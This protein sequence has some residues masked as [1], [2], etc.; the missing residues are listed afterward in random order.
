MKYL[1]FLFLS[2]ISLAQE[3]IHVAVLDTGLDLNKYSSYICPTGSKDFTGY[4]I[5]DHYGHGTFITDL[6]IRTAQSAGKYCLVILKEYDLTSNDKIAIPA[7][8]AALREAIHLNVNIIN[9]SGIGTTP[10]SEEKELI[11]SH[12][13]IKFIVAAGNEGADMDA[14]QNCTYPA[15]YGLSNVY[16]IGNGSKGFR[17]P[18]SNYGKVV[19]HWEDGEY[20]YGPWLDKYIYASGTSMST[21]IYTGKL[22]YNMFH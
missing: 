3:P 14:V 22:L 18:S 17:A 12:P 16:V 6:I 15:C 4:G 10:D 13:D 21:A 19:T 8:M 11:Q 7:Y 5:T 1:L 9:Y 2:S 20:I